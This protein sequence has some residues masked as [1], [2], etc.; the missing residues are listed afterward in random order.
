MHSINNIVDILRYYFWLEKSVIP[1][2]ISINPQTV[3]SFLLWILIIDVP[4]SIK[5]NPYII[6]AMFSIYNAI[7]LTLILTKYFLKLGK[8]SSIIATATYIVNPVS[9]LYMNWVGYVSLA[10]GLMPLAII[11]SLA[12]LDIIIKRRFNNNVKKTIIFS[13]IVFYLMTGI[14]QNILVILAALNI[15]SFILSLGLSRDLKKCIWLV[16][17]IMLYPLVSLIFIF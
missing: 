4:A 5:A 15:I 12:L 16:F 2:K 6:I 17:P 11:S 10:Y 3:P 13:V 14:F 9:A 1:A 8:I 7:F